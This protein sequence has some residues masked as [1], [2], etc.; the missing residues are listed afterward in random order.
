MPKSTMALARRGALATLALVLAACT[1]VPVPSGPGPPLIA[2]RKSRG[3]GAA[4][5]QGARVTCARD[6]GTGVRVHMLPATPSPLARYSDWSEPRRPVATKG[7]ALLP[8]RRATPSANPR[9]R[10]S[11]PVPAR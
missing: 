1:A 6:A 3:L 11:A 7:V 10:P 5:V 8:A 4:P 2:P 9:D